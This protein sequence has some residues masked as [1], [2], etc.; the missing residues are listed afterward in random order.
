MKRFLVAVSLASA[1]AGCSQSKPPQPAAEA[2]RIDP[3]LA[4]R[5]Q[6]LLGVSLPCTLLTAVSYLD[7][8]AAGGTLRG[9]KGEVLKFAFGPTGMRPAQPADTTSKQ[10]QAFVGA[11]YPTKPGATPLGVGTAAES[12]FIDVVRIAVLRERRGTTTPTQNPSAATA[13]GV[14]TILERQR[15]HPRP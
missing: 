4:A 12:V 1:L 7:G 15:S 11:D 6:A 5:A 2:E 3:I 8:G 10:Y 14:I 9:A 13:A